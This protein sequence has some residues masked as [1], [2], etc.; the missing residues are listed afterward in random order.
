MRSDSQVPEGSGQAPEPPVPQPQQPRLRYVRKTPRSLVPPPLPTNTTP[1]GRL[2]HWLLPW[3]RDDY[4]GKMRG[5]RE[6]LAREVTNRAVVM[7][8]RGE[9]EVPAWAREAALQAAY[10]QVASGMAFIRAVEATDARAVPSGRGT[11]FAK[12]DPVTGLDKRPK[13]GRRGKTKQV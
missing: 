4:P 13:A 10:S 7:W 5:R 11:G 8:S 1:F 2:L 6:I 3:G 9:R 12:V